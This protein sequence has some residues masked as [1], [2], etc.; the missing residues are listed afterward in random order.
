MPVPRANGKLLLLALEMPVVGL[1]VVVGEAADFTPKADMVPVVEETAGSVCRIIFS[2]V[3]DGQVVKLARLPDSQGVT[4]PVSPTHHGPPRLL[5]VP[6]P[7]N[8]ILA[9]TSG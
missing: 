2:T 9:H 6:P 5:F 1:S 8:H 3:A 7:Q 4:D